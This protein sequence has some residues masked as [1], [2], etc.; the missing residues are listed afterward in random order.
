LESRV[1]FRADIDESAL[2]PV[3]HRTFC[4]YKGICS[5]YNVGDSRLAAWSYPD[6]YLEVN[7]ISSLVSFEPDVVSVHLDDKQLLLEPGQTFIPH[8]P[9]RDLTIDEVTRPRNDKRISA[10]PG[11]VASSG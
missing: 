11:E 6:T 2:I 9:D 1:A 5:Y 3:E 8:G 4:P 7:R 10:S